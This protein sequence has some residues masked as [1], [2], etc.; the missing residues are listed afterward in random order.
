VNW[1]RVDGNNIE[2][3]NQELLKYIDF[4]IELLPL[5][6]PIIYCDRDVNDDGNSG[7]EN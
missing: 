6:N 7:S 1:K 3:I 4:L 2:F 5:G